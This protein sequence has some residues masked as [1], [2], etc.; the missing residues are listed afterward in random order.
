MSLARLVRQGSNWDDIGPQWSLYCPVRRPDWF[1]NSGA[2]CR[3]GPWYSY[4]PRTRV[5]ACF[6]G[7]DDLHS[8]YDLE[9]VGAP[10][11]A[12]GR[13]DGASWRELRGGHPLAPLERRSMQQG[14]DLAAT[15]R[16]RDVGQ[17]PAKRRP[18]IFFQSF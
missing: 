12:S 13:A 1:L 8:T 7:L 15:N 18:A 11:P 9:K 6:T 2:R 4:T 16:N 5:C 14:A 10:V 17:R 3:G